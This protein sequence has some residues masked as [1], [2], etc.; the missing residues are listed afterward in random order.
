MAELDHYTTIPNSMP[1][2]TPSNRSGGRRSTLATKALR[3]P[4]AGDS[5]NPYLRHAD[6]EFL[7]ADG[8]PDLLLVDPDYIK[9]CLTDVRQKVVLLEAHFESEDHPLPDE[10][11]DSSHIPGAIQVHPSYM[12]AGTDESKYY[13]YYDSPEDGN[14]LDHDRLVEAIERLGIFPDTT[15]IVYGTEPEGPMAAARLVWA[16]LYAG[17]RKVSVAWTVD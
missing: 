7:A 11:S 1:P 2:V 13:P 16:L 17:V 6:D 9:T 12:E 8:P 3:S 10:C 15:V 4:T 14:L 5:Q